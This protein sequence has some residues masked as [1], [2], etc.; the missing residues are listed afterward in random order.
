M[1]GGG[2]RASGNH[3]ASQNDADRCRDDAFS[4]INPLV[5]QA[6]SSEMAQRMRCRDYSCSEFT[7]LSVDP[8]CPRPAVISTH[9]ISWPHVGW[10]VGGWMDGRAGGWMHGCMHWWHWWVDGW[11]DE[12]MEGCLHGW[13]DGR[14]DTWIDDG[15]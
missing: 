15:G 6:S 13:M 12:R 10:M 2:G 14:M 9:S 4:F 11:V 7:T 3:R 1:A 8:A 5:P